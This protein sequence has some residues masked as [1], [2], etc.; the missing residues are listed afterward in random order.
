MALVLAGIIHLTKKESAMLTT[1]GLTKTVALKATEHGITVNAICPGYVLTPL[2]E[3][4]IPKRAKARNITEKQASVVN[5]LC[6][7]SQLRRNCDAKPGDILILTKPVGVGVYS[8]A[9]KKDA[10]SVGDYRDMIVTMTRLNRVGAELAKN[11]D[12]HAMT[13]RD[14]LCGYGGDAGLPRRLCENHR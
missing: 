5:G 7:P 6:A 11:P 12:V 10:L 8:A 4:R 14:A 1:L 3:K 13:E 9:F 2:V